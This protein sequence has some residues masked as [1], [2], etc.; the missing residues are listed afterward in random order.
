M[1]RVPD[2]D[3]P[4]RPEPDEGTLLVYSTDAS[5]KEMLQTYITPRQRLSGY[6]GDVFEITG[7]IMGLER[8]LRGTVNTPTILNCLTHFANGM[9]AFND[10]DNSTRYH[11][12]RIHSPAPDD[13]TNEE[14]ASV[15]P[16]DEPSN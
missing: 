16:D 10:F 9:E 4:L 7:G 8:Q 3:P 15:G 11:I 6:T 1:V 13:E 12:A 2:F 14:E 5:T